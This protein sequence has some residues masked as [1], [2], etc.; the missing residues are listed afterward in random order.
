VYS[1]GN[2][3]YEIESTFLNHPV[4]KNAPTCLSRQCST[5]THHGQI[6]CHNTDYVHV[7]GH[8]RTITVISAKHC[9]KLPDDGSLV[10]RN[11]LEHFKYF[12]IFYN[13]SNCIYGLYICASVGQYSVLILLIIPTPPLANQ[14]ESP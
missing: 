5:H 4:F 2:M 11:M 14:Q 12:K 1:S 13:N 10:I 6:C 9:I 8:D 7:N 3:D